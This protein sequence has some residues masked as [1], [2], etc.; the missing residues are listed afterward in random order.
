MKSKIFHKIRSILKTLWLLL[1]PLTASIGFLITY[2]I[3]DSILELYLEKSNI[4]KILIPLLISIY[5]WLKIFK[6]ISGIGMRDY[7][8]NEQ[9][10][11]YYPPLFGPLSVYHDTVYEFQV[12]S[13][14][15]YLDIQD[16]GEEESIKRANEDFDIFWGMLDKALLVAERAS[17]IEYP[18]LWQKHDK[19]NIMENPLEIWSIRY[20]TKERTFSFDV[21]TN[22]AYPAGKKVPPFPEGTLMEIVYYTLDKGLHVL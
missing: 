8:N 7:K 12:D 2:A 1:S 5:V 4:Y 17:R 16:L 20:D 18:L 6:M 3:I 19:E 11:K 22:N 15:I 21:Y 14:L 9:D 13:I 10:K